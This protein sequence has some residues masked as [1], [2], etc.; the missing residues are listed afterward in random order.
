MKW[1]DEY[2][3]IRRKMDHG[4]T[5]WIR[6]AVTSPHLRLGDVLDGSFVGLMASQLDMTRAGCTQ[7][8]DLVDFWY[9]RLEVKL[10]DRLVE[11]VPLDSALRTFYPP[12]PPKNTLSLSLAEPLAEYI[13][14]WDR[15]PMR[16]KNDVRTLVLR[17]YRIALE[18]GVPKEI[19]FRLVV[20]ALMVRYEGYKYDTE[21]VGPNREVSRR[22]A[23]LCSRDDSGV[24]RR[25]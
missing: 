7:D 17:V 23:E 18:Q 4:I 14:S 2:V 12:I 6:D 22:L 24:D 13:M 8:E 11:I 19:L 5:G 3:S 21:M 20:R 10:L 9:A 1:L 25:P 15:N 16:R